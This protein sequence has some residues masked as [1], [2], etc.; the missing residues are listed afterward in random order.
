MDEDVPEAI[1]M[2]LRLRGYDVMTVKEA[3]RKGFA[4]VEQLTYA[5]SEKRIIFT[6]NIADFC[7]IHSDFTK[8]GLEHSGIILS[9]QLPT[10]VIVRALLRLL[11]DVNY[12]KG[13]NKVIWLSDWIV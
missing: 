1:A 12:E 7:K 5:S 9:K 4:D 11:S 8:R 10:G 13:R 6:H 2:A 3:G